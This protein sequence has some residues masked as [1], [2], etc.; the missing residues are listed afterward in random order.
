MYSLPCALAKAA[1]I[2]YDCEDFGRKRSGSVSE[3]FDERLSRYGQHLASLCN[4]RVLWFLVPYFMRSKNYLVASFI[5]LGFLTFTTDPV[6][7]AQQAGAS[8]SGNIDYQRQVRPILSDNCF[9]CHGPDAATRMVNLRL[10]TKEGAFEK[11]DNGSVI[12]PGNPNGSLLYQRIT[13]N[14]VAQRMPPEASHKVLTENQ[15]KILKEW[16]EQG[17][18]WKQHWSFVPVS[19]PALPVVKNQAW[20]KNSID[21]F[22]LARLEASDLEPAPEADK[23]TLI[24]RVSLDLTG[25]PPEPA[26]VEA[27]VKDDSKNS[28]EKV[29]DRLL[30]STQWG[31][32]RAR[33]WLDAA[34]YADTHGV[35]VDNYREMWPYRDWVI[36]AF[37]RN[38][39]FD[40]FTVEQLAGDLLPNRTLDQQIASGFHRCNVTTNEGGVIPEEVE[41]I[42][43]KDRVDTTGTVFLGLTVGCATCHDHKFDPISTKDF[44]SLAA[45]F[46]NTTQPTMDGNISDTPPI[47]VVPRLEDRSQWERLN[48]ET[49]EVRSRMEVARQKE[50]GAFRKWIK[51]RARGSV[52]NPL[53]ATS[54]LLA[55]EV[56]GSLARV[57]QRGQ[58]S[59]L[60]LPEGISSGEGPTPE[61]S[62]LHFGPNAMLEL[63]NMDYPASDRAFSLGVWIYQPK[64]EDNFSIVSQSDPKDK[65]RG[66]ALE[67]NSR[68]PSFKLVG[69]EGKGLRVS[70]GFVEQL[71]VGTWNHLLV[72]Y[73][74]SRQPAGL[75]L[76]L[77]G[78][79]SMVQIGDQAEP[80]KGEIRTPSPLRIGNEGT[81]YFQGGALSDLRVFNRVLSEEEAHL[82]SLWSSLSGGLQKP[83]EQLTTSERDAFHV[84]FLNH[85]DSHYRDLAAKLPRLAG[86]RRQIRVRGSVTHVMEERPDSKP[87]AN[88]L[89]RGQYDQPREQVEPNVPAA[90][91]P[92][93]ASF[94]RN[95]L[96]LARWLVEPSNPLMARVTVNRF[97]QE[98]FGTGIVKTSE[99]FGSQGQPPTHPELLDWLAVE[100]RD[101]GWDVKRLF[102]LMVTSAAYQ[103]SS[104]ASEEKLK[105]DPDNRLLS[106]GPRFR[107]EGE[108]VR[109]YA[110][111][112]SG[113][114][115]PKI[116]G[117]SVKPYQPD[118]IWEAVAMEGSNTR[119]YKR[120]TGDKLY[121]R[122]LYTFW[123][124]SAPPASMDIFNAPTRESCTV[125]RERTDTPLQALVTLN[126]PQFVEAARHLAERA[127]EDG[128]GQFDREL[129]FMTLRLLSRTFQPE[130]RAVAMRAYQDYLKYYSS[131]V[132]D[133]TKLLSV[134]ESKPE[135]GLGQA[136]AAALTMVANQIMNLDEVLNK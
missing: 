52:S 41:A 89:Y 64:R 13:A 69:D 30:A 67:V 56:A 61:T 53:D 3:A 26:E 68:Q 136:D 34:R 57:E 129:D 22:I 77:N 2:A 20:V 65:G 104:F 82:V 15:K 98:I 47:V 32:H 39:P 37:N 119:F 66:W 122:S 125:R 1:A 105:A 55:L 33:Y 100:F 74:G 135:E 10:D 94:P 123:K 51:S 95:R 88:I 43:A 103:Q 133:A 132:E 85:R 121:R 44:Y 109:D 48:R 97:W 17:A 79:K 40:R 102:R 62:A 84:Y 58:N 59:T 130:E 72:T 127:L 110:L 50:S 6:T 114:L 8:A 21:A 80:L 115:N 9:H 92:L 42:Y 120:D 113:L 83:A 16:I 71:K 5:I 108:M 19:R 93:P 107:M 49:A 118:G 124:R 25:L 101:S 117:P 134:G 35:H 28:Y 38:L 54:Q 18:D 63:T 27:F 73:D 31:E 81:R 46:R 23:R 75:V 76:Y 7:S 78:K 45:F 90:L 87:M 96:G 12:V 131:H 126:D 116:G 112:V 86:E 4:G 11:R 60:P 14:D 70:A 29:V 128:R 91:P 111:S 99:D 36:N 24:R 106:R